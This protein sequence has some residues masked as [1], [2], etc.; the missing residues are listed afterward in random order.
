MELEAAV[1]E[2]STGSGSQFDPEVVAALLS[3]LDAGDGELRLA[4]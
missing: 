1:R 3:L 2:I 4:N